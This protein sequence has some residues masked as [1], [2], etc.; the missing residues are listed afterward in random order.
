MALSLGPKAV[1]HFDASYVCNHTMRIAT[2]VMMS[3]HRKPLCALPAIDVKLCPPLGLPFGPGVE[4][5]WELVNALLARVPPVCKTSTIKLPK[6]P[7]E[8]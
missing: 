8:L 3:I 7:F 2:N 6:E 4:V 1:A 5:I